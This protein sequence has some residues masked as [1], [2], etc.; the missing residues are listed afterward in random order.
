MPMSAEVFD[1]TQFA[2]PGPRQEGEVLPML[3]PN[4]RLMLAAFERTLETDGLEINGSDRENLEDMTFVA[5]EFVWDAAERRIKQFRAE[6][7]IPEPDPSDKQP[8]LVR[9]KDGRETAITLANPER[10]K[11]TV[12]DYYQ[13]FGRVEE[14]DTP[15]SVHEHRRDT[16]LQR[17]MKLAQEEYAARYP[18]IQL[19]TTL[20]GALRKTPYMQAQHSLDILIAAYGKSFENFATEAARP[21]MRMV[22]IPGEPSGDDWPR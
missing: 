11:R 21:A 3:S 7:G 1:N 8:L 22:H 16:Y 19:A 14:Q 15:D 20:R 18:E 12:R 17:Y 13:E 6:R 10:V 9:S 4:E 5:H 2:V